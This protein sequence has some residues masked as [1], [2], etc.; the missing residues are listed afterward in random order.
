[1]FFIFFE[2]PPFFPI[3]FLFKVIL[4]KDLYIQNGLVLMLDADQLNGEGVE[5]LREM[6]KKLLKI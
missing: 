5:K 2:S 6:L 1:M 4:Q 3:F